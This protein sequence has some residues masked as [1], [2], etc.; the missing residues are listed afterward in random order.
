MTLKASVIVPVHNKHDTVRAVLRALATQSVHSEAFEVFVVDDHCADE[1][2]EILRSLTSQYGFTLLSRRNG[3][4]SA[5]EARNAGLAKATG[6]YVLLLDSDVVLP[7]D[8]IARL[9]DESATR[10]EVLLIETFGSSAADAIWE[11]HGPRPDS[12]LEPDWAELEYL[13]DFRAT[14]AGSEERR[15]D[16]LTA[17]WVFFW[18]TAV[19]M[20][21]KRLLQT[22]GFEVRL[23]DKGSEDIELGYRLHQAGACFRLA[24]GIKALHLPHPRDR[25]KQEYWDRI[26]ERQML[27]CHPV[28]PM[29]MLCAFDAGNTA[30]ALSVFGAL[31]PIL[32]RGLPRLRG[33]T[34][35]LR[36]VGPGDV[37][38]SLWIPSA[39]R[40]VLNVA[41]KAVGRDPLIGF[42]LP[43]PDGEFAA[44]V[45]PDLRGFLPEAAL[46]R[47]LQEA[48]RVARR[49]FV[50]RWSRPL[51]FDNPLAEAQW[52]SFDRPHWERSQP[53]SRSFY[54]WCANCVDRI[55]TDEKGLTLDVLSVVPAPDRLAYFKRRGLV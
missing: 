43:D 42:A 3:T 8:A 14:Q 15:F 55:P 46:C 19:W 10:D 16:H 36:D 45:L 38:L 7:A 17:P 11:F 18:T 24:R 6:D 47:L 4:P 30:A 40:E 39:L 32:S 31:H 54:D 41:D 20:D 23:S 33:P 9:F 49:V 21:R 5:S 29:E 44:A 13:S 27:G 52:R 2:A 22:G 34:V 26:H 48:W 50:L 28:L 37:Y 53:V 35:V 51:G 25:P 12:N 1:C